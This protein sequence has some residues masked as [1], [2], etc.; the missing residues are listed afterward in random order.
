MFNAYLN[1]TGQLTLTNTDE[2][3][4]IN[5]YDNVLSKVGVA[6]DASGT[7]SGAHDISYTAKFTID[8][9]RQTMHD[10]G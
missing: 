6:A 9:L 10:P 5:T 8:G 3:I 2:L 4:V 1:S 7:V